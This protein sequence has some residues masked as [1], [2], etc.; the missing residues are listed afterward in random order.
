MLNE[1]MIM[2]KRKFCFDDKNINGYKICNANIYKRTAAFLIDLLVILLTVIAFLSFT[3]KKY[4][5]DTEAIK[6]VEQESIKQKEET[7]AL[8]K[9]VFNTILLTTF[10]YFLI[11]NMYIKS[12]IGQ[13][14]LKL[15]IISVNNN[16]I[17]NYEIFNKA[18]FTAFIITI[19]NVYILII[20]FVVP[21]LLTNYK[22]TLI[23]MITNTNIIEVKNLK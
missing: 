16:N 20:F 5:I 4:N 10:V 23:D 2:I 11:S 18:L 3:L 22:V 6:Q 1:L 19:M 21:L 14:I 13:K 8:T 12:T 9:K 17:T 15:R 7:K